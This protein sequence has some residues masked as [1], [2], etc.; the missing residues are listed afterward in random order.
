MIYL[1]DFLCRTVNLQYLKSKAKESH[2]LKLLSN[3]LKY[4]T[5]VNI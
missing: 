5:S 1:I 2:K 3:L 4:V